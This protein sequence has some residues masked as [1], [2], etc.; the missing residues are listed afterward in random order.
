LIFFSFLLGEKE[1]KPFLP[2]RTRR[3]LNIFLDHEK[4]NLDITFIMIIIVV[5]VYK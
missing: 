1:Q 5:I 3:T 2:V 4:E